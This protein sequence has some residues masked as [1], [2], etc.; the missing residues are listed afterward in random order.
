MLDFDN[1]KQLNDKN[2]H[3]FGDQVL[4]KFSDIAHRHLH[5]GDILG[6]YGGE[7]F[8]FVFNG[9]DERQ[10]L[11]VLKKIQSEL[12]GYFA[13][14]VRLPVTFSVGIV[15]VNRGMPLASYKTLV[16]QADILLYRAK[17]L[18]RTRAMSRLGEAML[19]TPKTLYS[20]Q[21]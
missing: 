17:K 5:K 13:K 8:V 7:E 6:R 1:F 2:G 16:G 10:S 14:T 4:N 19:I 12:A 18:G 21:V 11:K 9:A 3:L 20:E 15:T